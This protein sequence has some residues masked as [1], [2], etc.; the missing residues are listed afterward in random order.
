MEVWQKKMNCR[1]LN[2]TYTG[3]ISIGDTT[4]L[5]CD[6][7]EHIPMP[8]RNPNSYVATTFDG[9]YAVAYALD[10]LIREWCPE[11]FINNEG[12]RD[13]VKAYD[14]LGYL[15]NSSFPGFSWI[16]EFDEIGNVKGPYEFRQYYNSRSEKEI[17]IAFW[18]TINDTLL[19]HKDKMNWSS[20]W[21][22]DNSKNYPPD[23]VCGHPCKPRLYYQYREQG[24][25]WDCVAC[26]NNERLNDGKT[27]CM[28]CPEFYWPD[29]RTATYCKPI[30][31]E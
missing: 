12:V 16:V 14:L 10:K 7:I 9:V 25:C 11:K 2:D 3:S 22:A 21:K 5:T 24:C 28:K 6:G 29:K 13:C 19:L 23:S 17:R 18:N 27:G 1:Y 15:Q 4:L 26:R 8:T 31:P 20:F 30:E